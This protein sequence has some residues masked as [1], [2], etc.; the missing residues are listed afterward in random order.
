MAIQTTQV[1]KQVFQP[2]RIAAIS[3]GHFFTDI[4]M[5]LLPAIL[6]ILVLKYNLSNT[7]LGVM[8]ATMSIVSNILQPVFGYFIDKKLNPIVLP[9]SLAWITVIMSLIGVANNYILIIF[10]TTLASIGSSIYHPLGSSM[11]S[12]VSG[13]L[14]GTAMSIY[15]F[16]GNLGLTIPPLIAIPMINVWG[17]KSL[18]L[19]MIPGLIGVMFLLQQGIHELQP[20]KERIPQRKKDEQ[21]STDQGNYKWVIFLNLVTGLRQWAHTIVITFL[22]TLYMFSGHSE[23][24]AGALLSFFLFSGTLGVLFGGYIS[25]HTSKKYFVVLSTFC[26]TIF[27]ILNFNTS[28]IL[29]LV[30]LGLASACLQSSMPSTIVMAQNLLPKNSGLASGLMMGMTFSLGSLGALLTGVIGDYYGLELAVKSLVWV[31]ILSSFA[32]LWIPK[33]LVDN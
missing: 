20:L 33:R 26:S 4:Y 5:N 32:A 28:G 6:P 18:L 23:L 24:E 11:L 29:S 25:D 7:A 21:S 17:M 8:I 10:L 9:L 30:C 22:P 15:F 19:F 12:F 2:L 31:L 27:F 3:S 14:R 16:A 1:Q 13:N